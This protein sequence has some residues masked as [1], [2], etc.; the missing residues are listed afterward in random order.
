M[1]TFTLSSRTKQILLGLGILIVLSCADSGGDED[2][3]LSYFQPETSV[4][5][6]SLKPY[7]FSP[8]FLYQEGYWWEDQFNRDS[9]RESYDDNLASWRERMGGAVS[10]AD[11]A[12][13]LYNANDT[14]RG[15]LSRAISAGE[16]STSRYPFITALSKGRKRSE[17]EYLN[18]AFQVEKAQGSL[19]SWN[20]EGHEKDSLSLL[21]FLPKALQKARTT[22]D[23]FLRDRYAFQAIKIMA[24]NRQLEEEIKTYDEL[25]GTGVSTS[26]MRYWSQSRKAGAHL[27]LGDTAHSIYDFAQVFQNCPSRRYQAYLSL[28]INQVKFIPQAL[29]FCRSGRERAAVYALCAIQ[30][31]QESF[32]ILNGMVK[33]DPSD[34]LIRLVFAREVNKTEYDF[35]W[36]PAPDLIYGMFDST[37]SIRHTSSSAYVKKLLSFAVSATENEKMSAHSFWLTAASYLSFILKDIDKADEYLKK[38]KSEQVENS[39]LK[40][41]IALQTLLL[42]AEQTKEMTKEK[43]DEVIPLLESFGAGSEFRRTNA[44]VY[45]C[46]KIEQRYLQDIKPIAK[47]FI[48]CSGTG[49][50]TSGSHTSNSIAKAFLFRML[51]TTHQRNEWYNWRETPL[52][53]L[54]DSTPSR[55]VDETIQYYSEKEPSDYD[56]RLQKLSG[57]GLNYLYNLKGTRALSEHR[58]ND[59]SEA[60]LHVA[61]SNW[62]HD[63]YTTYLAANPFWTGIRDTHAK[64]DADTITFNPL[65]F[66]KRMNELLEQAKHGGEDGALAYYM[67]GC[68]AYNMTAWGN[69]WLLLRNG[70]SGGDEELSPYYKSDTD[71]HTCI[72][73]AEQHFNKAMELTKNKELAA[74]ACFMSAKCE[75]KRFYFYRRERYIQIKDQTKQEYYYYENDSLQNVLF[76]EQRQKFREYFRKL[77]RDYNDTKFNKEA[78]AECGYY[79]AYAQG[80]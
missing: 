36:D 7:H 42:F 45:A 21:E 68:G 19:G 2:A 48:G 29:T 56:N 31:W 23:T 15:E 35:L 11:I 41:Q 37:R 58:Y 54:E 77:M 78:L 33:D 51:P 57:I 32:D 74:Q 67:L 5:S 9:L 72:L 27:I 73:I 70:W 52:S 4:T 39:S 49:G 43:E 22:S 66:S 17:M 26:T 12:D 1:K 16:K 47:G 10:L 34:S 25:F 71:Y 44:F 75:Q 53:S 14:V 3:Y 80:K 28:R 20:D 61:D 63:P 55:I 18:F 50:G 46:R 30:P 38:A 40:D 59:A 24:V 64:V 60:F 79:Q 69:S 62:K 6:N 76:G 8:G 65:T 13:V